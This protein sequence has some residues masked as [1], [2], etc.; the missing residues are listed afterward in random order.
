M[1]YTAPVG[2]ISN[3]TNNA[4]SS[5]MSSSTQSAQ[6]LKTQFLKMLIA[7]LKNQDPTKPVDNS[8]M[9]AQQAQFASLE[10]MQNMN[11]NMV[12]LMAMQNVTQAVGLVGRS[13]TG[14]TADG[15]AVSGTVSGLI[16]T[17][18]TPTLKVGSNT[19]PLAL[20]ETIGL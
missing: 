2:S 16:F 4:S 10:Q 13:I 5:T 11:T 3:L 17:D 14:K 1:A 6:D 15:T 9:V 19:V 20:V 18:G 7:Q 8:Q 12:S